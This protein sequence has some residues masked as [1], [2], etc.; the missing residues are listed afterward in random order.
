MGGRAGV[1]KQGNGVGVLGL[2]CDEDT[3]ASE[4]AVQVRHAGGV[5]PLAYIES[6]RRDKQ[7]S[8]LPGRVAE[9]ATLLLEL[10]LGEY[11]S[12]LVGDGGLDDLDLGAQ[13]AERA[14]AGEAGRDAASATP[15]WGRPRRAPSVGGVLEAAALLPEATASA[16]R[17]AGTLSAFA[18]GL[19]GAPAGGAAAVAGRRA[20]GEANHAACAW[21]MLGAQTARCPGW[22]SGMALLLL[23][24]LAL[25][26]QSPGALAFEEYRRP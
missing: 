7:G 14:V 5:A 17:S 8:F 21:R 19:P 16:S 24:V 2:T 20:A 25:H 9:A 3:G 15:P 23:G 11:P 6:C 12:R 13:L 4:L 18:A 22:A 26:L 1:D 10:A